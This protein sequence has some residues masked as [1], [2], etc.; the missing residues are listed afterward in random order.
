[1]KARR[2]VAVALGFSAFV[3]SAP[4]FALEPRGG[5]PEPSTGVDAR[6][7]DD[8]QDASVEEAASPPP[9]R[10]NAAPRSW[11]A[12]G[13]ESQLSA[14]PHESSGM[15]TGLTLGAV[16]IVLGL[17][18]GAVANGSMPLAGGSKL[19]LDRLHAGTPVRA[20][21]VGLADLHLVVH[22]QCFGKRRA[23]RGQQTGEQDE[24]AFHGDSLNQASGTIAPRGICQS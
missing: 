24:T 13:G 23:G 12:R 5:S 19:L 6:G 1:M 9:A 15:G 21:D 22:H 2:A 3:V 16:L 7:S 20:L 8:K 10:D 11:L 14:A 17:G 18:A 4:S